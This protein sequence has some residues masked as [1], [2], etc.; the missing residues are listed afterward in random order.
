MY[1]SSVSIDPTVM[2]I[3]HA[4]TPA[5][6]ATAGATSIAFLKDPTEPD[7]GRRTRA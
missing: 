7:A 5:P 6:Q 1:V 2:Q 3:A 4:R